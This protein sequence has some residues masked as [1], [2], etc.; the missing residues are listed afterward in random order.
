MAAMMCI[1]PTALSEIFKFFLV[2]KFKIIYNVP[3]KPLDTH[4][5]GTHGFVV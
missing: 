4:A 5:N 1:L 3:E 2:L